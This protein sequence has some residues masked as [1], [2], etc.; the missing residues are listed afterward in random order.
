MV[1]YKSTSTLC[2]IY[3]VSKDFFQRRIQ[4]GEFIVNEH[5]IKQ[6]NTLR[7][8]IQAIERWWRGKDKLSNDLDVIFNRIL[9]D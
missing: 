5:Y 9:P 7:W 2:E 8:N 3:E 4:S 1:V 6:A